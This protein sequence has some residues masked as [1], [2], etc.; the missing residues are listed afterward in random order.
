MHRHFIRGVMDGDGC[1][2]G[3]S[4]KSGRECRAVDICGTYD[5]CCGTKKIIEKFLD[6][7]CMIICTNKRQNSDTYKLVVSG[8]NQCLKFLNWLYDDAELFLYRK[9]EIYLSKYRNVT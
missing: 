3:T 4:C 5:F 9:Y 6:I 8:K 2:H 7:N 1:I